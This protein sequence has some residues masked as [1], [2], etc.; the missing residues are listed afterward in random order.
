MVRHRHCP[1][2]LA[3]E[4]RC[5]ELL[6]LVQDAIGVDPQARPFLKTNAATHGGSEVPRLVLICATSAT[7]ITPFAF[8]SSRKF[9]LPT[10]WPTCALVRLTSAAL[11][12]A[13]PFTSPTSTPIETGTLPMCVPSFTLKSVTVILW[14]LVTP[15]RLTVTCD[16][17]T[18]KLPTLPVPE[19][20]EALPTVTG[21]AKLIVI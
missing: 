14:T 12:A 6:T 8:T 21:V 20:T 18:V 15:V 11:T 17:F 1:E 5:C 4:N 13:F 2:R 9:E 3:N 7:L 19:V 16:P 10:P